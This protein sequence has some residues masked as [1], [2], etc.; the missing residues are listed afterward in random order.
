MLLRWFR[1]NHISDPLG[2]L[3]CGIAR[4]LLSTIDAL[5]NHPIFVF[6][7]VLPGCTVR[8]CFRFRSSQILKPFPLRA[9]LD[10]DSFF[11]LAEA[12]SNSRIGVANVLWPPGE[13]LLAVSSKA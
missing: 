2:W 8:V 6:S 7:L 5:R 4:V 3:G 11:I 12:I 1:F 10:L 13:S 9:V